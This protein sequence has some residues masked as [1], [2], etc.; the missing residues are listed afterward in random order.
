LFLA[1]TLF[2]SQLGTSLGD[3]QVHGGQNDPRFKGLVLE[4]KSKWYLQTVARIAPIKRKR[5]TSSWGTMSSGLG[6]NR[7]Q[8]YSAVQTPSSTYL[9]SAPCQTSSYLEQLKRRWRL[10]SKWT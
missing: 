3:S 1:L 8:T 7:L 4:N 6:K 9:D 2:F 5:G 10:V